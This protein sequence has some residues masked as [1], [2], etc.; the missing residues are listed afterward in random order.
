MICLCISEP[1]AGSDVANIRCTAELDPTGQFFVVNGEKK[2]I[3]NGTFADFFTVAVRP[4]VHSDLLG[5]SQTAG[6]GKCVLTTSTAHRMRDVDLPRRTSS[7]ASSRV[8]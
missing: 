2:W 7:S 3:T 1:Y 6:D 4:S 5:P 8:V